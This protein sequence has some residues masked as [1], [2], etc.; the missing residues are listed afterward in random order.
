M[1]GDA[2]TVRQTPVGTIHI[3][4]SVFQKILRA[5]EGRTLKRMEQRV[6]EVNAFEEDIERLSDDE[7]G[8]KDDRVPRAVRGGGDP[9]RAAAR[10]V[11]LRPRGLE[12]HARPAPLRR[13]AGR[14][15]GAARGPDRR[16][17]DRRGQDAGRDAAA[18][19]ER[20]RRRQRAAGHRQRLPGPPRRGL[21]G[22]D[23][24]GARR[25]GRRDP[26]HDAGR[27]A[28]HRLRVRHHVRH[29]LGVRLRLPARQHG[30]GGRVHGAARPLVRDRGRGRLDPDRRGADAADH[31]RRAG[32]G[33]RDLLLLRPRRP[34][35][36]SPARTTRSTRSSTPRRPPSRASTRSSARSA[37]RTCTRRRTGSWSTT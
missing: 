26:E 37:S 2:T 14:R 16:D 4:M 3:V 13:P 18:V 24:P 33:R 1:G 11:R 29:Q 17:E 8:R 19:P 34:R 12:A 31:L 32:A 23:L 35:P 21:D 5:G 20:D 7:L 36:R 15:H 27:R 10:G 22:A 28:A 25:L 30:A 6:R 9:R